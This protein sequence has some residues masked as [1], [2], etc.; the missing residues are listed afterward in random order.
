MIDLHTHILTGIDDGPDNISQSKQLIIDAVTSGVT[1]LVATPHIHLGTFD[2]NIFTIKHAFTMLT[3]QFSSTGLD[4]TLAYAAEVRI[5]PEIIMLVKTK[6]LPFVGKWQ[7]KD[8]LLLEFPSSHIPPGSE[9]LVDWLVAQNITPLI[10]HPERNMQLLQTNSHLQPLLR[11][12]CLLQL[13]A[14]SLLGDFGEGA[15]Q[16]AWHLLLAKQVTVV[17]S[18]MHSID[19]RPCKLQQAYQEVASRCGTVIAEELFVTNP[20]QIFQSNKTCWSSK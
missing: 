15:K 13:T 7:G 19:K 17:A 1:H 10:A 5:C 6:Q 2:N 9:K 20:L 3:Q 8:L 4:F 16:F 11:R 12:G 18:D 14:A